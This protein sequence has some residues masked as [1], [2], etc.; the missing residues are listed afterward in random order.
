MCFIIQSAVIWI[1]ICFA[2]QR[3]NKKIEKKNILPPTTTKK[4]LPLQIIFAMI[5]FRLFFNCF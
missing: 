4:K 2:G 1:T 3:Y 5:A